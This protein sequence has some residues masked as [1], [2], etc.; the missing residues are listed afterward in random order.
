MKR[1]STY[2]STVLIVST[3]LLAMPKN[4]Y[5]GSATTVG[6]S[7]ESSGYSGAFNSWNQE[8]KTSVAPNTNITIQGGSLIAPSDTLK[9]LDK[10][11]S[12]IRDQFQNTN[13][14]NDVVTELML[15][16]ANAGVAG[17]RFQTALVELGANPDTVEQLKNALS[18]LL[19]A[20]QSGSCSSVNINQ[21]NQVINAYN[22]LVRT[23]SPEVLVKI[24]Q[25][26]YFK[27][28]LAQLRQ[29]RQALARK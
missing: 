24:S 18:N 13:N 6:T 29:M 14:N 28:T 27:N 11:A 19:P 2:L 4:A 9:E 20:C 17:F 7:E 16:S 25:H 5:A 10:V 1:I 26:P 21:L 8:I 15:G 23:S 3:A 22:Q 12:D